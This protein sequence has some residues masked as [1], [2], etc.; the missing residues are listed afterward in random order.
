MRIEDAAKFSAKNL[1]RAWQDWPN[2]PDVSGTR[3]D[4]VMA[5]SMLRYARTRLG[6]SNHRI[7][8][9]DWN[10]GEVVIDALMSDDIA[11]NEAFTLCRADV[12]VTGC[13]ESGK[14]VHAMV[15]I[16][17]TIEPADI[18]LSAKRAHI[19]HKATGLPIIATTI[20]NDATPDAITLAEHRQV[21]ILTIPTAP[22]D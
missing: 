2:A 10:P 3:Y 11:D 16:C 19:L 4:R 7:A 17:D 5:L 13:D 21:A 15:E 12:V 20:G 22:T 8:Q 14:V 9:P 1:R 18:T 6:L